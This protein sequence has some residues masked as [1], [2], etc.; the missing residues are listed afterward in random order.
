M[1]THSK[2]ECIARNSFA[3]KPVVHKHAEKCKQVSVYLHRAQGWT[4]TLPPTRTHSAIPI[5]QYKPWWHHYDAHSDDFEAH[6]NSLSAWMHTIDA[7]FDAH[8]ER[9][10]KS[11]EAVKA[12]PTAALL[13]GGAQSQ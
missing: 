11:P 10:G 5:F 6:T 4:L 12:S 1:Q 13:W 2:D 3:K 9:P 7:H 8:P